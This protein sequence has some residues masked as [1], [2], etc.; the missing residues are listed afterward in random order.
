MFVHRVIA[1]HPDRQAL[2]S[3]RVEVAVPLKI[4]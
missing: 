4:Q 3:Y 1:M 2:A